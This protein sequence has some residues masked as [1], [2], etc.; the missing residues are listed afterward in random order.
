M[1]TQ[2]QI[3]HFRETFSALRDEV[4]KVIVGHE[5]VVDNTLVAILA[6]GHVLLEGVQG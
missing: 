5:S 2:E 1:S 6:G 4:G 3:T